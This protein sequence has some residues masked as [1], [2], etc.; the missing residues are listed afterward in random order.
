MQ[1]ALGELAYKSET[2]ER[3]RLDLRK[4]AAK[5]REAEERCNSIKQALDASEA[6]QQAIQQEFQAA[7]QQAEMQRGLERR[8]S[9]SITADKILC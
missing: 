2:A 7:L 8:L 5:L 1:A 4:Q 9:V 6:S 3:L